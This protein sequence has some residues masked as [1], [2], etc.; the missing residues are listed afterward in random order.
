MATHGRTGMSRA[1]LGSVAGRILEHSTASLV[2]VRPPDQDSSP[3]YEALGEPSA[4]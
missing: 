4:I 2:L 3:A 1:V